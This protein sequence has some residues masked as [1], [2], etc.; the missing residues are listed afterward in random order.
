MVLDT[1]LVSFALLFCLVTPADSSIVQTQDLGPLTEEETISMRTVPYRVVIGCLL[2]LSLGT[3]P[4]I[5]YAVSQVAKFSDN[6]GQVHWKAVKRILRYLHSTRN[7]GLIFR[8]LSP[9]SKHIFPHAITSLIP[10][11]FV[12]AD[13]ARDI[14]TRRSCTGFVFF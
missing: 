3:R 11:G 1:F 2:W 4:D 6:P 12:D 14:S 5:T 7:M 8:N 10:T 9:T 13:Y